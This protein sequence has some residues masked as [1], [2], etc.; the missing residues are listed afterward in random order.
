MNSEVGDLS[1]KLKG[2]EFRRYVMLLNIFPFDASQNELI[3][4]EESDYMNFLPVE[5]M[6]I[7]ERQN[8]YI[9]LNV[10]NGAVRPL[11]ELNNIFKC[12]GRN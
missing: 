2:I 9:S 11:V 4:N 3:I 12:E 5:R 10:G 7:F 6:R 8:V 1:S